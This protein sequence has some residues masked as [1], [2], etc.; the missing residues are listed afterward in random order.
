MSQ[1]SQV[2]NQTSFPMMIWFVIHPN[3]ADP[4]TYFVIFSP[5]EIPALLS[6]MWQTLGQINSHSTSMVTGGGHS[7][8]ALYQHASS[9]GPDGEFSPQIQQ[10]QQQQLQEELSVELSESWD[11]DEPGGADLG[12]GSH[13]GEEAPICSQTDMEELRR[14]CSESQ[15]TA[16]GIM[17]GQVG[18]VA[19]TFSS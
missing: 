8:Y 19:E 9:S 13:M 4:L 5:S 11:E 18:C 1:W 3:R 6:T 16:T 14:S 15:C 2:T 7:S 12:L 17:P 10:Q